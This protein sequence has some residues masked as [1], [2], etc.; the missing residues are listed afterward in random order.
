MGSWGT[1]L[2][3]I[4]RS[5]PWVFG[6]LPM[7]RQGLVLLPRYQ[8]HCLTPSQQLGVSELG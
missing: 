4:L 6:D 1:I 5:L 2:H 7:E 3:F 8:K